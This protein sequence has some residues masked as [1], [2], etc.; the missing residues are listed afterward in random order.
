[1][2]ERYDV[3]LSHNSTDKSVVERMARLLKE[4]GLKPFLDK[5]HLIPGEPWQEAL[6]EALDQSET[7]AVF[8][9]PG[10]ISPWEHEEMRAA[11][12]RR[13]EDVSKSFR[14]IPVLLPGAVRG[15]RGRLPGFLTR[16]TWVEFG[17]IE[18]PEAIHRLISGIKGI[19]PGDSATKTRYNGVNPYRGLNV[20]DVEHAP[21]FFGREASVEWLV[22]ELRT[23]QFLAV[24]GPS[25]SGKSSLVRA[26]LIPALQAGK[27]PGSAQWVHG[28]LTPGRRPLDSLASALVDLYGPSSTRPLLAD[29]AD[30]LR[31]SN[32]TLYLE[33]QKIAESNDSDR[34]VIVIDQFEELFTLNSL[35][36]E[37]TQFIHNIVYASSVASGKVTVILTMRADFYGKCA[38]YPDLAAAITE[39]QMLVNPLTEEEL[40][41][42][43]E[44]PAKMANLSYEKGLVETLLRDAGSE[45]GNLPQVQ[46]LLFELSNA[47]T[48]GNL[49]IEAY[50][51]LGGIK[52]S[53]ATRAES[54]YDTLDAS[55]K[56]VMHQVMLSLVT[57]G[58]GTEDTRRKADIQE[59]LQSPRFAPAEVESVIQLLA[60]P[61]TRL[62]T[63]S[64]TPGNHDAPSRTVEV[65]HEALIQHWDRLQGWIEND[66]VFLTWRN[67]FKERIDE[68]KDKQRDSSLLLRGALLLEAEE[69]VEARPDMFTPEEQE[70]LSASIDERAKKKRA[71]RLTTAGLVTL[72]IL[73][74][75]TA[76]I[77]ILQN[78]AAQ[79]NHFT[80]NYSLAQLFEK[81]AEDHINE[82]NQS[83]AW[84]STLDALSIDIGEDYHLPRSYGNLMSPFRS[85]SAFSL[86]WS[87]GYPYISI[88]LHTV[89]EQGKLL[90]GVENDYIR[91]WDLETG[92]QTHFLEVEDGFDVK[93]IAFSPDGTY[94]AS[95]SY[96]GVLQVWSL[97]DGQSIG[98]TKQHAQDINSIAFSNDNAVV[99][100]GSSDNTIGLWRL[101]T[102]RSLSPLLVIPI[103]YIVSICIQTERR[104]FQVLKT[105]QFGCGTYNVVWRCIH[106]MPMQGYTK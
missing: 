80:S 38:Q 91:I 74:L 64:S 92:H 69:H 93:S 13:V 18:D 65:S 103:S 25:G 5:W 96:E 7:C 19:A 79:Q 14:V 17:D 73:A 68:W 70:Y 36:E 77:A 40:R 62:I 43:I 21:F 10:G 63:V 89:D 42:S 90:A 22:H 32:R 85:H 59:L 52:G 86:R 23:S 82:G 35:E 67:R 49:T 28:L 56:E 11:I 101:S 102:K 30:G 34:L 104:S 61:T 88:H 95:G 47:S 57:P 41:A 94:L 106:G 97:K 76:L 75:C 53:I 9:G 46:H 66:R 2:P 27:I 12:S 60:N 71:A 84:L 44:L 58:Q 24:I 87:I 98:S 6:E 54:I 81:N 50:N 26:G 15:A 55:K 8:I 4:Q 39:A 51:K 72:T 37:R 16:S 1:M 78:R 33:G 105:V 45:P 48:D 31:R 20:F 83:A 3:F 29:L 99:A 100:T